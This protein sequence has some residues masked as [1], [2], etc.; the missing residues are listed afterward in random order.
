MAILVIIQIICHTIYMS[1]EGS[2]FS[3]NPHEHEGHERPPVFDLEAL[4]AKE[5]AVRS[6]QSH[7]HLP[8][9]EIDQVE[10]PESTKPKPYTPDQMAAQVEAAQWN[11]AFSNPHKGSM[12]LIREMSR[13]RGIPERDPF[14]SAPAPFPR[15][16]KQG[17]FVIANRWNDL[18]DPE[19]RAAYVKDQEIQLGV[20]ITEEQIRAFLLEQQKQNPDKDAEAHGIVHL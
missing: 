5:H 1:H 7:G 2:H 4:G 16:T 15:L 8:V 11:D 9:I 10:V 20:K 19:K 18:A 12:Q 13:G 17:W 14:E 3:Q 6:E